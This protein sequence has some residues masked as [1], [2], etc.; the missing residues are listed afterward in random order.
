MTPL[1]DL[2]KELEETQSETNHL[3]EYAVLK[4]ITTQKLRESDLPDNA[5]ELL[6]KRAD[7][8]EKLEV[9]VKISDKEKQHE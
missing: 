7:I 8:K 2:E 4:L 6:S 1:S 9:L 5:L 3:L